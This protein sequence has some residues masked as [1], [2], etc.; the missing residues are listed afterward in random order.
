MTSDIRIDKEGVWHYKDAEMIRK[1]IVALLS[2]NLTRDAAGNYLVEMNE[3]RCQVA[4][5]DTP[6][7]V[8]N[9][10]LI[11]NHDKEYFSIILSDESVEELDLESLRV[12][13]VHVLY[14]TVKN[15]KF[16]ARFSRPA[17]YQMAKHIVHD[18]TND[19]YVVAVNGR[20]YRIEHIN[21]GIYAG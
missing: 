8:R 19:A 14:C 4:V 12:S 15:R 7:V 9:V 11:Q 1:D 2:Q 20:P 18:N 21:G 3:E 10:S 17:Y 5:E 6:F 16:S 13:D